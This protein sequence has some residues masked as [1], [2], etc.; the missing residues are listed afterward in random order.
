MQIPLPNLLK[1]CKTCGETRPLSEFTTDKSGKLGKLASCKKCLAAKVLNKYH[2]D[3][4]F[5]KKHDANLRKYILRV[6]Y[7]LTQDSLEA[8]LCS[9]GNRCAICGGLFTEDNPHFIDHNHNNGRVRGLL[10]HQCNV[11]LG[12]AHESED[13]LFSAA[14]YL[15]KHRAEG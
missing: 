2:T 11:L 13:I 1:K 10:H 9:Q 14:E 6:K 15:K 5:R 7:G 4:G 12:M 8:I 3:P